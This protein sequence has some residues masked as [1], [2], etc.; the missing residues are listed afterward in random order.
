MKSDDVALSLLYDEDL[1]YY[2]FI[3]MQT[4][5]VDDA[6]E[7][8]DF[9]NYWFS[10]GVSEAVVSQFI[11]IAGTG[12]GGN[13]VLWNYEGLDGEAPLV[14][15]GSDGHYCMVAGSLKDYVCMLASGYRCH[16]ESEDDE[17]WH[18]DLVSYFADDVKNDHEFKTLTEAEEAL[19]SDVE[20]YRSTVQE[21]FVCEDFSVYLQQIS[22]HNNFKLFVEAL[23][24]KE[25][26]EGVDESLLK[27][28][29][30][31][32]R[33]ELYPEDANQ[34][35]KYAKFL[36]AKD[37]F[38]WEKTTAAFEKVIEIDP[39]FT[40]AY[41]T[42]ANNHYSR[43]KPDTTLKYFLKVL[44]LDPEKEDI[45][46]KIA[47]AYSNLQKP[48]YDKAIDYYFEHFRQNP[49]DKYAY[50]YIE[51]ICEEG[52]LDIEVVFTKLMEIIPKQKGFLQYRI[53]ELS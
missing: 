44:E 6:D 10:D 15:F 45:Y 7:D 4:V 49:K 26:V 46:S 37:D 14:F 53:K 22:K 28:Q 24:P 40:A 9:L 30:L 33:I 2:D 11:P 34:Y 3:T 42:L 41:F 48:E 8:A 18:N 29:K 13:Y 27:E 32:K 12:D 52:G 43:K 47:K 36:R 21:H 25:D 39:S 20:R 23:L 16:P 51:D 35:Y 50:A 17:I 38:D 5:S 19:K 1:E 31:L